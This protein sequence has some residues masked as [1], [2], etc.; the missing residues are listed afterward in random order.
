METDA[1]ISAYASQVPAAPA[2]RIARVFIVTTFSGPTPPI[3]SYVIINN[4]D[5]LNQSHF[6]AMTRV[7][8]LGY[9]S[10]GASRD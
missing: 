2:D 6:R 8:T 9:L 1:P 3:L 7:D 10:L 5:V 4:R